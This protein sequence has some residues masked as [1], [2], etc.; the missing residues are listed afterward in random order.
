MIVHNRVKDLVPGLREV[1]YDSLANTWRQAFQSA[2]TGYCSETMNVNRPIQETVKE[3][4]R[5]ALKTADEA[6]LQIA[7]GIQ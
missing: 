1:A 3:C 6:I 2:L 4:V 5:T 7:K